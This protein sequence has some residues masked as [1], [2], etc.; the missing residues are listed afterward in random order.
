MLPSDVCSG[1]R[2]RLNDVHFLDLDTW[3]WCRPITEGAPPTP[4]EQ[5]SAAYWG[6][7]MV[8]F[9]ACQCQCLD[10][11]QST[12]R[13][14]LLCVVALTNLHRASKNMTRTQCWLAAVLFS[15]GNAPIL[16]DCSFRGC[17]TKARK[18]AYESAAQM[19]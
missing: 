9:G 4:R 1:E 17:C 19:R 13:R 2:K 18:Y 15:G 16:P 5:A 11:A 12:P 6:G 14:A 3:T 10:V 8:I 7:S